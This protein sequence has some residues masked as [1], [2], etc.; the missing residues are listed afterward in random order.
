MSYATP[1]QSTDA[2]P[3]V[4]TVERQKSQISKLQAENDTVDIFVMFK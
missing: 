4:A 2:G 3:A 1:Q